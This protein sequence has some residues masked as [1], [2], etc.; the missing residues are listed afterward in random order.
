MQ[1]YFSKFICITV[2]TEP[3]Q[4]PYTEENIMNLEAFGQKLRAF[5]RKMGLTQMQ[6]A[7]Q[8]SVSTELLS[9]WER[10]YQHKGRNWV[11]E[12]QSAIRLVEIFAEQLNPIETQAWLSFIDIHL[13]K[14]ELQ[15]IFTP[16]ADEKEKNFFPTSVRRTN[17]EQLK[18][19]TEQSLFG[20]N[21]DAKQISTQLEKSGA[22]WIVALDGIGGIG[23]TSL[24]NLLVQ[25]LMSA[26]RF[27]DVLWISAKQEE[28]LPGLALSMSQRPEFTVA[29][30]IDAILE[31]IGAKALFSASEQEK[32][33]IVRNLLK[34]NSYL[35][36][37]DNLEAVADYQR[38]IPRLNDFINPSKFLLTSRHRLHIYPGIYCHTLTELTPAYV[39]ELIKYEAQLRG[40][41][42]LVGISQTQ[43]DALYEV[44]GGNPLALKLVVGQIAFLSLTQALENLIQAKGKTID[45][46]YTHIYWQAW[47]ALDRLSKKVLL[48]MPLAKGGDLT[49]IAAISELHTDELQPALEQLVTLSLVVVYGN[50]ENRRY[51]IHRLTETFLLNEVIK[52]QTIR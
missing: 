8:L 11:P 32:N 31:Q 6:L 23:K 5:R 28:F 21:D 46:L 22:P 16:L 15:K 30:L 17:F 50:L 10:A 38:W 47:H 19:L 24:T 29:M 42:S 43:L 27:Y 20:I 26:N 9:I 3:E 2:G 44:V 35:I 13:G 48:T 33:V 49:Y 41:S 51:N 34:N 39:A 25:Q 52:W 4:N 1:Q 7:Q 45:D 14:T 18:L 40:I 37:I 36:V 12:R